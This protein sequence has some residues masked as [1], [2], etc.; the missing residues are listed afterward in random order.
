MGFYRPLCS[1]STQVLTIYFIF[2]VKVS[3]NLEAI[4]IVNV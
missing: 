2:N 3:F 4:N 1:I